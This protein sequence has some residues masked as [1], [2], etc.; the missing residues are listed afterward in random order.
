MRSKPTFT[1]HTKEDWGLQ[2][3][4]AQPPSVTEPSRHFGCWH[5]LFVVDVAFGMCLFH[6]VG[7]HTRVVASGLR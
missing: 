2:A 4:Q 1:K 3:C 5:D 7:Q 6:G